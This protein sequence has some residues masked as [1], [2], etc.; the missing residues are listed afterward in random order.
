M[1]DCGGHLVWLSPTAVNSALSVIERYMPARPI[2]PDHTPPETSISLSGML[3]LD[4]WYTSDVV[5]TLSAIDAGSGVAKMEYSYDGTN[6]FTYTGPVTIT[7]EGV[8]ILYYRS[9]DA[10]GNVEIPKLE[11]IKVDKT[12]PVTDMT[13]GTHYVD[14]VGNVYVTSD[15]GFTLAATDSISGV[16][17]T[18]YRINGGDWTEYFGVFNITDPIGTR[19]IEYYS[20]DIAGNEETPKS[21]TVILEQAFHGYGKLLIAKQW[22][23]G[24]ATLF[25]SERMIRIQVGDQVATWNIVKHCQMKN[26]DLYFSEGKLGKM[27]L[28]IH[29]GQTTSHILAIGRWTFFCSC[30]CDP[31]NY[32]KA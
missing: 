29:R 22:F 23:K 27:V 25:L 13:I 17:H 1:S 9:I 2:P 31:P 15:T 10:T 19:I 6:W 16:G 30:V 32:D 11:T 3:G 12:P 14:D 20:V 7:N 5:V 28:I 24:N 4:G 18:Y 8:T 21:I 26:I